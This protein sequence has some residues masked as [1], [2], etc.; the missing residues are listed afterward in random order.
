[1]AGT[2]SLALV[3]LLGLAAWL[4]PS[5]LG[6][7]THQQLGLPPCS[8]RFLVHTRCPT[9]GMTTAWAHAVR[10]Q[11]AEGLRANAGG[12]LLAALAAAAAPWLALSAARG[13]WLGPRPRI[14][15]LAVLSVVWAAVV[16]VEWIVRLYFMSK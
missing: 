11:V 16:L 3:T 12:V 7:G 9:C 5:D 10:G 6:L 4:R 2:L 15:A 13:R 1:M 14:N 8:F